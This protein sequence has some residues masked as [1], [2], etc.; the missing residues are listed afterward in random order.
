M[1]K[2]KPILETEDIKFF[3][4]KY[5][6][7]ICNL[8]TTNSSPLIVRFCKI[9]IFAQREGISIVCHIPVFLGTY[10]VKI[11]KTMY[12]KLTEGDFYSVVQ[13]NSEEETKNESS[14]EN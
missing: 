9:Q 10:Y 1:S 2:L 5:R 7:C 14:S 6:C 8:N 11:T 4:D 12:E 3:A 13:N